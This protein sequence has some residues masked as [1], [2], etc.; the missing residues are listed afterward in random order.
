[1]QWNAIAVTRRKA[2]GQC[3][4]NHSSGAPLDS[5]ISE[6]KVYS[7]FVIKFH[8]IWSLYLRI[9]W[10]LLQNQ[11]TFHYTRH[12][13]PFT[14][15]QDN[16]NTVSIFNAFKTNKNKWLTHVTHVH[17]TILWKLMVFIR[18]ITFHTTSS[19]YY[20]NYPM[21][22]ITRRKNEYVS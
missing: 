17:Y 7:L 1:M 9:V 18:E 3:W 5:F 11:I 4:K 8:T 21:T 19:H 22:K 16:L 6:V 10:Q 20:Y 12:K 14:Q 2:R 13:K 15:N